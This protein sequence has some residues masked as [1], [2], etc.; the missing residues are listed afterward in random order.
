ME[1]VS[2]ITEI[3]MKFASLENVEKLGN[4]SS[5]AQDE[6]TRLLTSI[7]HF[8]LPPENYMAAAK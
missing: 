5:N 1:A 4:Y 8:Y 2:T 6:R 7:I 3:D